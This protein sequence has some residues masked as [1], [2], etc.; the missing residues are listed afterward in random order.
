MKK[1]TIKNSNLPAKLPIGSTI[2]YYMALDY[3]KAPEWLWTL[4]TLLFSLIWIGSIIKYFTH[5]SFDV[6]G[7]VEEETEQN[8]KSKWQQKLEEIQNKQK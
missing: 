5:E 6:T 3:Y 7:F 1:K 2:M 4:A 8:R